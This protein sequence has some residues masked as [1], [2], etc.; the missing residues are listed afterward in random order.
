MG[1]LGEFTVTGNANN[2]AQP[3]VSALEMW[4]VSFLFQLTFQ[5]PMVKA[6]VTRSPLFQASLAQYSPTRGTQD[7]GE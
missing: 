5:E 2:L 6:V 4:M 1:L 7:L 3:S